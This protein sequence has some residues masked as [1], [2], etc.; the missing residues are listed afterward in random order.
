MTSIER[1]LPFDSGAY[2]RGMFDRHMNGH[3]CENFELDPSLDMPARLVNRFFGSNELYFSGTPQIVSM[4]PFEL[5]AHSYHS[6][7]HDTGW[8]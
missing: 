2:Y 3:S 8:D 1:I 5:E 6:L 4:P 7:I